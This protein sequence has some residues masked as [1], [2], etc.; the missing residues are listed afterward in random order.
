[1]GDAAA[2]SEVSGRET[3]RPFAREP[4]V[5][6]TCAGEEEDEVEEVG[7]R[8]RGVVSSPLTVARVAHRPSKCARALTLSS[9]L[10]PR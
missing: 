7:E 2:M 3:G 9:G 4:V 10:R 6:T 8:E 5:K 1:M